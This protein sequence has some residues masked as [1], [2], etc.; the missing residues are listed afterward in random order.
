MKA[1]RKKICI[2]A[3]VPFAINM[4]ME[5]HIN[6]LSEK[7][8]ITLIANGSEYDLSKFKNDNI[9]FIPIN[10]ERNISLLLDVITLFK[11]YKVF[12]KEDFDVVHTLTPKMALLAIIAAFAARVPRRIHSFTG[13]V[14]A[15]KTGIARLGLKT[16]DMLV[17]KC[18]TDL[19]TDSPSQRQFLID[20][21]IVNSK[22]ITVLGNGSMCGVNPNRFKPNLLKRKQIRSDLAIKDSDIVYL[23]LGRLNKDK[24]IQ[25]LAHA[26]SELAETMPNIHLIVVG[27][28][29]GGMDFRLHS[30]LSG[31]PKQY[32]RVGFTNKPEDYMAC[33]DILCL[34]SYREGFGSVLIEAASV[35]IPSVASR[36]YGITDAVIDGETGILHQ[37]KNIEEIKHALLTLTND[38][39]LHANMSQQAMN[40]AHLF[41][42]TDLISTAMSRYYEKLFY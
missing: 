17:A 34:P 5:P 31:Y 13:Q 27:P 30:I 10:I 23:F 18:A 28:D 14:W 36:I 37:P 16:L 32:H 42:S 35:G 12:L 40:R 2:A 41:F 6:M 20:Q 38:T 3:T 33:A 19:L 24:G 39:D 29:E 15:N 21:H 9:N 8:D 22:K 25:D 1:N 4:F 7:Y 26:F 11:L